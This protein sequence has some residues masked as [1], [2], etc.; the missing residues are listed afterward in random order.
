MVVKLPESLSAEERA[1]VERAH[2]RVASGSLIADGEILEA[3]LILRAH[4]V[5]KI[6]EREHAVTK[7][8][9]GSW[10]P[11][12]FLTREPVAE[13][14]GPREEKEAELAAREQAVP[15][16]RA[17]LEAVCDEIGGNVH[18]L[19]GKLII[20]TGKNRRELTAKQESDLY[21]QALTCAVDY[22]RKRD[23]LEREGPKLRRE[24]GILIRARNQVL[25]ERA[26]K[27][28]NG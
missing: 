11:R 24:I 21:D 3:G 13:F 9:R 12:W 15:E 18:L 10:G 22:L 7:F 1:I 23:V 17:R 27:N 19:D 5:G 25:R 6:D 8:C 2:T 26:E 16:A 14:D 20:P 28:G 4:G